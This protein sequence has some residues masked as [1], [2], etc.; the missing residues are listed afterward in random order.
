MTAPDSAEQ[1]FLNAVLP[2]AQEGHA[3][4]GVLV[5][6]ILAQ[7]ADETGWGTSEA[8][9]TGHNPAGI[10]PGGVI[11]SYPDIAAG[12]QAWWETMLEAFY[13]PVRAARGWQAQASALGDSP[14]AAGHYELDG[15]KG[16]ALLSI[17]THNSLWLYDQAPQP[18][19]EGS[20]MDTATAQL[21]VGMLYRVCLHRAPDEAGFLT[22][23]EALTTGKLSGAQVMANIQGS[24][25]GL[26]VLAAERHALGL[27]A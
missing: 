22:N 7:W 12:V 24:P 27:P 14:W 13:D 26:A 15:I 3:R 9:V 11:A 17:I 23:V 1:G 4:T 18:Q 2:Y 16:A 19:P 8:W 5:S 20:I 21:L 10:S 25:E 6:V